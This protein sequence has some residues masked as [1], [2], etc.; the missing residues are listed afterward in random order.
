MDIIFY[1]GS[2]NTLDG[3]GTVYSAVGA[4]SG[5]VRALGTDEELRRL[6]GPN[7]DAI[8]LKG[9][10]LFPGFMEAHNHLAI[11]GYLIDGIDLSAANAKKMER[12]SADETDY[13]NHLKTYFDTN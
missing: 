11:Y 12:L 7:T 1:N 8:D 9:A 2:V 13:V 6:M 3:T 10:A 5:M 4:A